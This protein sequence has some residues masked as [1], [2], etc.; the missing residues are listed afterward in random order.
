MPK[1]VLQ[2]LVLADHVYQDKFTGKMVI[3]G[4]FNRVVF[5]RRKV[6]PGAPPPAAPP[7]LPDGSRVLQPHEVSR[8]GSPFAYVSL[9]EVH[10]TIP[11]ELRYVD[12][13]DNV[14]LLRSEFSVRSDSP[15][16][17]V[18]VMVQLPPLPTMHPGVFALELL[19]G[20]E[21]LGSHRVTAVAVEPPGPEQKPA[22]AT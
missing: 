4:T 22:G 8:A 2:A 6:E 14:V 11:L 1:P 7:A 13:S 12:L 9:T 21:L 20:T 5:V 19:S 18:E 16:E 10:G 3:A 15:L 17:T